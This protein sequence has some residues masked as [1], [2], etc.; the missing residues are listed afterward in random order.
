VPRFFYWPSV[1]D[2]TAQSNGANLPMMFPGASAGG[3]R[4]IRKTAGVPLCWPIGA[5]C[6]AMAHQ[7]PSSRGSLGGGRLPLR[8]GTAAAERLGDPASQ[9]SSCTANP[10]LGW[11]IQEQTRSQ[12]VVGSA[13]PLPAGRLTS[14]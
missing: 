14:G 5:R 12:V 10:A 6:I 8:G 13:G 1:T 7:R 3:R 11:P 4:R 9:L 2:V